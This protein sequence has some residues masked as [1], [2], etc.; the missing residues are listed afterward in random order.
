MVSAGHAPAIPLAK[1]PGIPDRD[2]GNWPWGY[3]VLASIE[4]LG[5]LWDYGDAGPISF[6][7]YTYAEITRSSCRYTTVDTY[8][9]AS[10]AVCTNVLGI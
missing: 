6:G 8:L 4:K 5:T 2:S 7:S 1:D 10:P 9:K 3:V